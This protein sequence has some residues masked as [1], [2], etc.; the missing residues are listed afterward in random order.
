MVPLKSTVREAAK[1]ALAELAK[2]D[3]EAVAHYELSR[4]SRRGFFRLMR[5]FTSKGPS[6]RG[7]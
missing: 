4:V 2:W 1:E 3:Q 7:S 6:D 5:E